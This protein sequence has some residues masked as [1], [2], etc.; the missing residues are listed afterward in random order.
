MVMFSA[1]VTHP[2]EQWGTLCNSASREAWTTADPHSSGAP[3]WRSCPTLPTAPW[4]GA[5]ASRCCCSWN[6]ARLTPY[7]NGVVLHWQQHFPTASRHIPLLG[8]ARKI[9]S[10]KAEPLSCTCHLLSPSE[11]LNTFLIDLYPTSNYEPGW[12]QRNRLQLYYF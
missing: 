6:N 4:W 11:E 12:K 8:N 9:H 2:V 7:W 3:S 5:V 10:G 1:T